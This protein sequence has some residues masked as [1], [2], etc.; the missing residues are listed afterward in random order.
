MES[1]SIQFG[2][3]TRKLFIPAGYLSR[4]KNFVEGDDSKLATDVNIDKERII[5]QILLTDH[6][7]VIFNSES[8]F[9]KEFENSLDFANTIKAGEISFKLNQASKRSLTVDVNDGK[10]YLIAIKDIDWDDF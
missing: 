3:N 10:E 9:S 6:Y 4:L 2:E 5:H 8:S 7:K 1:I